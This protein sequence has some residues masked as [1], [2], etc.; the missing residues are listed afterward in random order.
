MQPAFEQMGVETYETMWGPSEF[1]LTG[2]LRAW[3]VTDRIGNL[4]LPV[5]LTAGRQDLTRP[6]EAAYYRDLIPGAQLHIFEDSAHLTMLEDP[7]MF[8]S[9]VRRFLQ[10]EEARARR[11]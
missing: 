3:D 6:E 4:R 8:V 1:L 9:I 5:L 10:E 11:N 7:Q 2:N